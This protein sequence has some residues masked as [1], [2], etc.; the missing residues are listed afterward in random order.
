MTKIKLCGLS[1]ECDILWANQL[2]PEYIGFVFAK[3]SRRYVT[4]QSAKILRQKLDDKI[5]SVGVFV[6]EPIGSVARLLDE[7]TIGMAQLHGSEDNPYIDE[8]RKV[9][10][11]P[12]IQAFGIKTEK[13]IE[14][15]IK[16][17]ADYILLDSGGGTG[18]MFNHM[19]AKDIDREFFLAGGLSDKNVGNAVS[20]C[21]P[22]CVDASSSLETDGVKDKEKMAAFVKAV[23]GKDDII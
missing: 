3:S 23:R 4:P 13:D 20:L 16:S 22:Y 1:R 6:N 17:H 8:L 7:G 9:T 5:V 15:A 11:S 10:D 14:N 19:L 21:H 2:S 12:I 18:E